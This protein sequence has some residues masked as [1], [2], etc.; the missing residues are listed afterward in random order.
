L[1]D[2]RELGQRLVDLHG[3]HE[4]QALLRPAEHLS[5]LDRYCDHE[6]AVQ[7]ISALYAEIRRLGIRLDSLRRD[8]KEIARRADIL[9]FQIQEIE[10]AALRPGEMESLRAERLRLR[11]LG[12]IRDLALSALDRLYEGEGAA[13]ADL[14]G[15]LASAKELARLDS[16]VAGPLARA[17]E[18]RLTLADLA[19]V[20]REAG[21]EHDADPSRLEDVE[22]R[23]ALLE[24]LSRKYGPEESDTLAFR[25]SAERELEELTAPEGSAEGI[26]GKL[27]DLAS[28]FSLGAEALSRARQR[29]GR[30]LEKEVKEQLSDL[31]M[32][33]TE[34]RV[35]CAVVEEAGSPVQRE[36]R[37]VAFHGGGWDRVQFLIRTNPGEPLLPLAKIASGGEL[38]RIML[39][40]H[41]ALRRG[42]DDTVRVFDE[43]DAGIGGRIAEAVGRKLR[44]LA[45]GG[46]ILCVTH[47]PQIACRADHHL[48]V[49]KKYRAGRTEVRAESLDREGSV[50]E[51]A[52]MLG[53]EK[54]SSLTLQHA[55]EMVARGR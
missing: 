13:L 21:R 28:Q 10:G 53:G 42:E 34:L 6:R 18:A 1:A 47:L 50:R 35:E 24:S 45:E 46:Q 38:S 16:T 44:R 55:A 20:L 49:G 19:D 33:S 4:H 52:R 30:A 29:G 23:L 7:E 54:I 36:A 39:A 12:K 17:E 51:V 41:L 5:L 25:N 22:S 37:P 27:R 26:E 14:D 2:L 8:G 43:V 48:A 32:D 15:A 40:V 3:Q 31:A 9:N 11:N